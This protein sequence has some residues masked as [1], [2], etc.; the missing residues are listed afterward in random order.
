MNPAALVCAGLILG[1]SIVGAA[2]GLGAVMVSPAPTDV[3]VLCAPY[4]GLKGNEWRKEK[5]TY[6]GRESY[7]VSVECNDG[8][9]VMRGYE[10]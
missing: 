8:S 5:K 7:T 10:K 1:A 2:F 3:D 4:S 9:W 6:N